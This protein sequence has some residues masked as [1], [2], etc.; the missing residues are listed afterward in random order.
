MNQHWSII[1]YLLLKLCISTIRVTNDEPAL[2][3]HYFAC[4]Q[5]RCGAH[6]VGVDR[7]IGVHI[8]WVLTGALW[9][10]FCGGWQACCGVH[11]VGVDRHVVVYILWVLTGALGCTFC[12]CWQAH[13]GAH[14][15]G[16]DR[17]VIRCVLH[18]RV[19]LSSF[20]VLDILC[21]TPLPSPTHVPPSQLYCFAL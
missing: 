5:A 3:H 9:C 7:R 2:I 20:T 19:T 11:S 21:P 10:T 14:Y 12:G 17:Y 15:V 4:W 6:S 8:L 16:V 13:W 1:T 18:H